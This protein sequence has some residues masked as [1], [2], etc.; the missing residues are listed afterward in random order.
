M[1]SMRKILPKSAMFPSTTGVTN[2]LWQQ[3]RFFK[4]RPPKAK[5]LIKH[6]I[7]QLEVLDK[8]VAATQQSGALNPENTA[9]IAEQHLLETTASLF[10]SFIRLGVTPQNIFAI[11]KCYSTCDAVAASISDLGVQ[12][13]PG[14][15]PARPGQYQKAQCVQLN[16]FWQTFTAHIK[17]QNIERVIVV[18]D[19]GR[20]AEKMPANIPFD[21][22][23]AVVEQ[24]RGGLYSPRLN[25]LIS[26]VILV[27]GSALKLEIEPEFVIQAVLKKAKAVIKELC[28]DTR[29]VIG[30]V[31][32]GIIG[33]ELVSQ[34]AADGFSIITYDEN[35]DAFW[36]NDSNF[37]RAANIAQV[38]ANADVI[39]SCTGKKSTFEGV[40]VHGLTTQDKWLISLT[41][42]DREFYPIIQSIL[43]KNPNQIYDPLDHLHDD[44]LHIFYGGY[45]ANFHDRMPWNV[46][47]DKIAVT[48]GAMLMA[49]IQGML[50][51]SKPIRDGFTINPSLQL[52]LDPY[53]QRYVARIWGETQ[54]KP[55]T[56]FE[57]LEAILKYSDG[58][59]IP[60][61]QLKSWFEHDTVTA[62]PEHTPTRR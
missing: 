24:T 45:P 27:A 6:P 59:Y 15:K 57:D 16:K 42:E 46:P 22:A 30:I 26:K 7:P 21:Y 53:A 8:I 28:V 11:G 60:N 14:V 52:C 31:G 10:Q 23:T 58:E 1:L 41:S 50:V 12:V 17:K 18:G 61:T 13:F 44:D 9:I 43:E 5:P 36:G 29:K 40:D 19:G 35:P 38:I 51:A 49:T 55:L 37:Y 62:A 2:A 48:Q 32:N 47:A 33:A 4:F 39:F 54:G 3:S 25:H 34:L 20:L 56:E